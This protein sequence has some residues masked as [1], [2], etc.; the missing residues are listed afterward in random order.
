MI[1]ASAFFLLFFA[2]SLY[3]QPSQNRLE[4]LYPGISSQIDR[5][6]K[7][8]P[9]LASPSNRSALADY[10]QSNDPELRK[11]MKLI[12]ESEL[13]STMTRISSKLV[14]DGSDQDWKDVP[15]VVTDPAGDNAA[16]ILEQRVFLDES[17]NLF[18]MMKPSLKAGA[19]PPEYIF[20]PLIYA[21][22]DRGS[23][24]KIY[25]AKGRARI[26]ERTGDKP[27]DLEIPGVEAAVGTVYEVKVPLDA[28]MRSKGGVG[29]LDVW[30]G[31]FDRDKYDS[32]SQSIPILQTNY[33]LLLLL[34]LIARGAVAGHD[35][36]TVALA[37]ANSTLYAMG[38]LDTRAQIR[39]D[40]RE[41][42][43]LYRKVSA[44]QKSNSLPFELENLPVIPKMIW[45]ARYNRLHHF[46][47][48]REAIGL[49][50]KKRL[51][52][53]IYLEF[54]D[55]PE[56]LEKIHDEIVARDLPLSRDITVLASNIEDLG[57]S[58]CE[59][60]F[61]LWKYEDL[62]KRGKMS[63]EDY[64]RIQAEAKNNYEIEYMGKKRNWEE[65]RWN[66][67][68]FQN[69]CF[70]GSK[71][72]G[73][74]GTYTQAM[75]A[76]YRMAGLSSLVNQ[77]VNQEA[78]FSYPSTHNF[79]AYYHPF[80]RR[81]VY[82]QVPD[83]SNAAY[84]PDRKM[85]LHLDLPVMNSLVF[86]DGK[87]MFG[88][89]STTEQHINFLSLGYDAQKLEQFFISRDPSFLLLDRASAPDGKIM[90]SDSDGLPD[91]LELQLG[92]SPSMA[93][94]DGDGMSDGWEI[95]RGLD[96]LRKD[97]AV[98]AIDGMLSPWEQSGMVSTTDPSGDGPDASTDIIWA[99]AKMDESNNLHL[100][101]KAVDL[102]SSKTIFQP[103]LVI[104]E[105][106]E[107]S[108]KGLHSGHYKDLT[109][110]KG[111]SRT[112]IRA[113][114]F[115]AQSGSVYEMMIPLSDVQPRTNFR[116]VRI[117]FYLF[118]GQKHDSVVLDLRKD[119]SGRWA[120][121]TS[122]M[123]PDAESRERPSV[124]TCMS[125][126]EDSCIESLHRQ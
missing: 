3:T 71:I 26:S 24:L 82:I 113:A 78:T 35:P 87:A 112:K 20:Q 101:V 104:N 103:L 49:L 86:A 30:T 9:D 98:D 83:L 88:G 93:D 72:L 125:A 65:F 114:G 12:L 90:D 115:E 59:T 63:K 50:G 120:A 119:E 31:Y 60:R 75:T 116:R 109:L 13:Q 57:S 29:S 81:W 64:D 58:L 32:V 23:F 126:S 96:P 106:S 19:I 107:W 80:L 97:S 47:L 95:N 73:D 77:R 27:E 52:K 18:I 61:A 70:R 99:G 74:C 43:Q 1:R 79:P 46:G 10:L 51:T 28:W 121:A 66:N 22:G 41:H 37:Y 89:I 8:E 7:L 39:K 118:A 44:W 55:R 16:D 76:I 68:Q 92:T 54:V 4:A 100:V 5:I 62:Y 25:F 117:H 2:T 85:S 105:D 11:G 123:M 45:S 69:R 94:T 67:Y 122:R 124:P 40:G 111:E 56:V 21:N 6:G 33:A 102:P 91:L 15:F 34:D 84:R 53:D 108:I 110:R 48:M 17:G 38:D 42:F 14:V 36:I